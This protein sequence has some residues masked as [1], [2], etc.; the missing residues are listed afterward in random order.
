M[1]KNISKIFL[2]IMFLLPIKI[3]ALSGNV[4]IN[5]TPTTTQS[6]SEISC[7]ISGTSDETVTSIE[8]SIDTSDQIEIVSFTPAV[9]QDDTAWQGE[10]VS[11]K[12]IEVYTNLDV[13]GSFSIGTLK[14]KIKD[15]TSNGE[16]PIKLT[17]IKFG[18]KDYNNVS[19]DE[20]STTITIKNVIPKGLKSLT[21]T[22]GTIYQETFS[23]T[24]YDYIVM[25][26]GS[27]FGLTAVPTNEG[28]V[29]S[30]YDYETGNTLTMDN[31]TFAPQTGKDSMMIVVKVGSGDTLTEYKLNIQKEKTTQSNT[32]NSLSSLTVGGQRVNLISNQDNYTVILSDVT[33][34]QIKATLKDSINFKFDDINNGSGTYSGEKVITI[35]ILPTDSSSGIKLRTYTITVKKTTESNNQNSSSGNIVNPQTSSISIFIISVILIVSLIIS[36]ALFKKNL[37]YYKK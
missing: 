30:V 35:Q 12:K 29:A 27:T 21:I 1:K 26:T 10:D 23:N 7:S 2:T 31:I 34:Y 8:A 28:E 15:G 17:N 24:N 9:I 6:P 14:L 13:S 5:C 32:D 4:N 20:V 37:A 11:N 18:N 16:Q 3:Y 19:I 25:I 22:G 33:S 36:I